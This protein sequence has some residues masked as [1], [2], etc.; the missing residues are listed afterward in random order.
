M[1]DY[2]WRP[3]PSRFGTM[4]VYTQSGIIGT[5]GLVHTANV[6]NTFRIPTPVTRAALLKLA[7]SAGGIGAD[8]DGTI[9]AT[10]NKRDNVAAQNV[11]LTAATSL[12][13]DFIT[14]ANKVYQIPLLTTQ[15][16]ED[17]RIFQVGDQLYVDIVSNSAAIDTQPTHTAIVA[18]W[19]LL[20]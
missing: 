14:T 5:G 6:T 3:R 7:V 1:P 10:I 15:A 11:A 4:P 8:A 20:E 18:E 9:L 17:A 13:V 16:V 19:G 2:S 12:E